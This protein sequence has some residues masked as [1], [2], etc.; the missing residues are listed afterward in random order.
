MSR[1]KR[2]ADDFAEE[3]RAHIALEAARLRGEGLSQADAELAA[4]RAFG[5]RTAAE[6]TFHESRRWLW[7]DAAGKDLAYALRTLRRNPVF[8]AAAALT[9]A[10]GIGANTAIFSLI[11]TALLRPLP[12]PHAERIMALYARNA[13]SDCDALSPATFLDYRRQDSSFEHLAAY[14]ETAFNLTGQDRPERIDG[15]TVTPDFFAVMGVPAELGRTL[16]VEQEAPGGARSVVLGYSLWQRRF[17]GNAEI[18]GRAIEIDG[19][20]LTVVGVMPPYFRYPPACEAWRPA[21]YAVPEQPLRPEVNQS[22]SRDSHYFSTIARLKAGTTRAEALAQADTIAARLRRLYGEDEAMARATLLTLQDDLIGET[23]P[24]LLVLL[25]AVALLLLIACANVANILLARGASRQKEIAIRGALGAGRARL[26]RQFL[27]EGLTLGAMG[28]VLGVAV[29]YLARVPLRALLPVDAY[30]G[31]V[32][33]LNARVLAFTALATVSSAVLF[34]LFPALQATGFDLNAVLKE[35]ARGSGAGVRARRARSVLVVAEVALAGVLL[36]GAGLLLRSFSRLLAVPEG[37]EAEHVLSL[38]L[39]LS[40]ARYPDDAGRARLVRQLLERMDAVPGV[41]AAA[42]ISRLPLNPGNSTR[43]IDVKGRVAPPG[44]DP[45]PDYLVASP[46]YFRALGIRVVKGRA[47]TERD[48]AD[49]APVVIVNQAMARYFWPQQDPIGQWVTVGACGKE[50]EWCQVVGVVDD[51]RQHGLDQAPRPAVYVPYARDP[52][53][54]MAFVV[55]TRTEPAAAA[56]AIESAVYSVD[57]EQ[58]VFNVRP[59]QDVVAQSLSPRRL[60]MTLIGAF[61]FLALG[62]A[63]VGIYGVTAYSVAQ[64]R[65]EIGIRMAL[66]AKRGDVLRT[67]VGEALRLAVAG[68]AAGAAMSLALTRFLAGMLYGIQLT[69]GAT[70]AGVGILL[71]ATAVVSSLIPAWRAARADPLAS[72]RVQ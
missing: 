53:P 65:Q 66:G 48:G 3:I 42:A 11:D 61:A 39:T 72:L 18:L 59:M 10:L 62:L 52:W 13:R 44:G 8:T 4:R 58:P 6:E 36:I 21:R 69:D 23:R 5:N 7:W 29:A 14:R 17:G 22:D 2:N 43:G 16:T 63:A 12:Y 41:A 25:G 35:A 40:R 30:A 45:G 28:G 49:A 38:Q 55:R 37:F 32:G 19:E 67:V 33:Q 54:F 64:R 27:T 70:Y 57:K 51:V 68:V 47:F 50:N 71:V 15:A 56:P 31:T 46:G 60:R 26:V 20:P 1:P 9:L 24:A 34:G